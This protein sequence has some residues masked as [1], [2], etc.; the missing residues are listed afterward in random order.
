[1][2]KLIILFINLYQK[3]LSPRKGYVCAH[4][5]Y[6]GSD[7]CSEYTKKCVSEFGV[8]KSIPLF[9]DRIDECKKTYTEH[10][11]DQNTKSGGCSDK[12]YNTV[13]GKECEYVCGICT[14]FT[15]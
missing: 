11:K 9:F 1:M 2:R 13:H 15:S 12:L 8:I 14:S 4:R 10:K 3:Y 5:Y 6:H 7:S